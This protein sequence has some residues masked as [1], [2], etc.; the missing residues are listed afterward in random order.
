[1]PDFSEFI[2][3]GQKYCVI[4][5]PRRNWKR[6]SK[7]YIAKPHGMTAIKSG[8]VCMECGEFFEG[9]D[10]P[11]KCSKCEENKKGAENA[12]EQTI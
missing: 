12:E 5:S 7:V 2:K 6:A 1:M 11:E 4:K 8:W 9:E 10:H 3:T